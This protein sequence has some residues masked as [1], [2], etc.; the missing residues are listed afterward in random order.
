MEIISFGDCIEEGKYGIHSRF[1]NIINFV[2]GDKIV[3]LGNLKI[4]KGPPNIIL[5][6]FD[7]PKI[8][9]LIIEKSNIL[10]DNIRL[11]IEKKIRFDSEFEISETGY[12]NLLKHLPVLEDFVLGEAHPKS[13]VFLLDGEREKNFKSGFERAFLESVK[14]GVAE[15]QRGNFAIGIEQ[16][17]GKGFG[18]TPSGDD[19]ISG[20]L[21]GLNLLRDKKKTKISELQNTI[22]CKAKTDN[23]ISN[24]FLRLANEGRFFEYFKE[25]LISLAN[26][27]KISQSLSFL[28]KIILTGET[29]GAD[30]MT[31]FLL[32]MKNFIRR[33]YVY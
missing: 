18:L 27:D 2:L 9:F 22:F 32:T 33:K 23:L 28:K 29:S 14:K 24:T 25:M 13:L 1:R 12:D 26:E 4:Q 31:G 17:K 8:N 30:M 6:E 16:I 15:M 21:Y 11:K 20:M 19:F 7:L 3:S 10:V 5:D